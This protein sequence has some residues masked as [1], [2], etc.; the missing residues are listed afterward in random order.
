MRHISIAGTAMVFATALAVT[1][2]VSAGTP[3]SIPPEKVLSA[4]TGDWNDDGSLDR[5]VLI[6][7]EDNSSADL[8]IYTSDGDQKLKLGAFAHDIAFSGAIFG[9]MPQLRIDEK[10]KGALQVYS[11]NTGVGRDKWERTMT[12]AFRKG[13]FVVAGLTLN[14][15]DTLNPKGGG[16]CD[17]NY[18][19]GTAK[20]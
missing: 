2:P 14:A 6:D 1:T 3:V 8:A 19:S 10:H 13:Q 18:L 11:E 16:T 4:I 7:D 9:S 20:V 12:L 17:I 15:W 5:A